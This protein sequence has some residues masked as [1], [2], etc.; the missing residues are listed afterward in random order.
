MI[1]LKDAKNPSDHVR[2][3]AAK[4]LCSRHGPNAWRVTPK[5]RGKA[6]RLVEFIKHSQWKVRCSE[7]HTG[8]PCP[9]NQFGTLCAH[10]YR[11]YRQLQTNEIRRRKKEAAHKLAA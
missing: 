10:V 5:V 7:L 3:Y 4:M 1:N 2:S 11:V 6:S 9:A 8:E